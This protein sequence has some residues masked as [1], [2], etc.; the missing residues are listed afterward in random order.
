MDSNVNFSKEA[1]RLVKQQMGKKNV[2]TAALA[3]MMNLDPSTTYRMVEGQTLQLD[4]L[5]DLSMAFKYNFFQDLANLLDFPE[6][7]KTDHTACNERIRELEI[8][9]RV[10][11]NL[12]KRDS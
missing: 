2:N 8:E 12:L 1:L 4:K 3:R 6:P 5:K 11:T 9:N 10:L 7:A